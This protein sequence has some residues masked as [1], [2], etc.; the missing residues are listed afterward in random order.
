M[1]NQSREDTFIYWIEYIMSFP[2]IFFYVAIIFLFI[3]GV[4]SIWDILKK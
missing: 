3:A 2:S 1:M 4:L